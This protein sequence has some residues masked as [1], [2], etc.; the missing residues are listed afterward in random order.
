MSIQPR[1]TSTSQ[2]ART[3]KPASNRSPATHWHARRPLRRGRASGVSADRRRSPCR[4][5]VSNDRS[6]PSKG[7]RAQR[8]GHERTNRDPMTGGHRLDPRSR[9]ALCERVV[10]ALGRSAKLAERHTQRERR[11]GRPND[12]AYEWERARRARQ[13]VA[14]ARVILRVTAESASS[15]PRALDRAGSPA[16]PSIKGPLDR[17]PAQVVADHARAGIVDNHAVQGRRTTDGPNLNRRYRPGA[18]SRAR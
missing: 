1:A 14:R 6:L 5:S 12:A 18:R 16:G 15:R 11:N 4:G 9:P 8:G 7:R 13:I 17:V 2:V 10:E 3:A